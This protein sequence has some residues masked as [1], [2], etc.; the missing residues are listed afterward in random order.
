[1]HLIGFVPIRGNLFSVE[2]ENLSFSD[3]QLINRVS[4]RVL[5]TVAQHIIRIIKVLLNVAPR[6]AMEFLSI[7][8]K[9]VEPWILFAEKSVPRH[10]VTQRAESKTIAADTGGNELLVG[11]FAN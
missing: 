3:F 9:K 6:A 2:T 11:T 1:M 4:F 5:K 7:D 8:V 10:G